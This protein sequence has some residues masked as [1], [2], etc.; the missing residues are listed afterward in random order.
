MLIQAVGDHEAFLYATVNTTL[1]AGYT[2]ADVYNTA[3]KSF[4]AYGITQDHR[5]F[6]RYGF[7]SR[8]GAVPIRARC[9]GLRCRHV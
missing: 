3:L 2:V 4:N 6:S 5:N 9:H 8:A 1:A 7:S